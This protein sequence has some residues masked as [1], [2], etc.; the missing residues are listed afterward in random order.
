M[1]E[2]SSLNGFRASLA[3]Q[4]TRVVVNGLVIL[5]LTR[6]FFTPEEYGLL[7]L[8]I[9][10]FGSALLFSRM[11]I[12]KSAARY[13]TE[14]REIDPGQVR[15]IVRTSI[16]AIAATSIVV[17]FTL[18]V[19]RE[20]IA[21]AFGE[22]ALVSLLF[23]GFFYVLFRT[24]NNYVYT[25]FQGFNLIERSALLSICSQLGILVGV[26][27][28]AALGYGAIG[29]LTGYVVGY[30]L[31]TLVGLTLLSRTLRG[32]E[33]TPTESGLRRRILEYS[34]PLTATGAANILYKRVDTI[35]V[36]FFLSPV[37]VAY[38]T[39]A[40]QISDFV[41]A[42]A[43]ALGFTISPSYGEH[44]AREDPQR[45]ARLYEMAFEHTILFYV[46]AAAGLAL[47][48]EPTIELVFGA[49]YAGATPV[50]QVFS[51]FVVL[52]AI[53]KITNDGLDYLGRAKHRA[54]VKTSTG[55]LNFGLNL[56]LIPTIGVVGAAISTV[57]G[58]G[59]MVTVN[60]YLIHT[61][62]RLAIVRLFRSLVLVGAITICMSLVV[63]TLVPL[64]SNLLTLL[65]VVA[66]GGGVWAVL[67]LATGIPEVDVAVPSLPR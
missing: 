15:N 55:V 13:V 33:A 30:G 46:P 6:F 42:P 48:A 52:Q 24:L 60:V 35:L 28:F 11:G 49:D 14:Y 10:I 34:I 12:Q 62:L 32:Y 59:I 8:A 16:A 27:T 5:L 64:V 50:I 40:K 31:G 29:G 61:E 17:G 2:S 43:D 51:I 36:G 45:A 21:E 22:P 47:V 9:S 41:I 3:A 54:I 63:F 4:A 66:V 44:K 1:T 7:F 20:P 65:V 25:I 67:A 56:A 38:Y 19:L 57:I 18:V 58:Y 26:V 39:L 53:D 37:A 23:L